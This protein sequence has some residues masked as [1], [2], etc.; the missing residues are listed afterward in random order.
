M[1][2]IVHLLGLL[3]RSDRVRSVVHLLPARDNGLVTGIGLDLG[4]GH[5][6]PEKTQSGSETRLGLHATLPNT[7]AST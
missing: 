3:G 1:H 4:T 5:Q 2:A 7:T 6:T